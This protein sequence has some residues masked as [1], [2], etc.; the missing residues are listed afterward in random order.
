M[1]S[2]HLYAC[3]HMYSMSSTINTFFTTAY[4][5]GTR[6]AV[7]KKDKVPQPLELCDFLSFSE[8]FAH[9]RDSCCLLGRVPEL[10]RLNSDPGT[11]RASS[12]AYK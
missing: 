9:G 3:I 12:Y 7:G 2:D 6:Y 10:R 5:S 8:N 1:E 11:Q 4:T